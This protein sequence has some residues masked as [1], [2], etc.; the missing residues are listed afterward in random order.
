MH[1][2]IT[3]QSAGQWRAMAQEGDANDWANQSSSKVLHSEVA[4]EPKIQRYLPT[5]HAVMWIWAME[6]L[7]AGGGLTGQVSHWLGAGEV[8]VL[9]SRWCLAMAE[10]AG[11]PRC[12]V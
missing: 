4:S 2:A 12:D 5:Q 9:R 8:H 10:E 3:M 6:V 11:H 1:H 7:L